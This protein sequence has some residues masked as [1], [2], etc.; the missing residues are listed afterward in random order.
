MRCS[1]LRPMS[2]M[3]ASWDLDPGPPS[4]ISS[5]FS[6]AAIRKSIRFGEA[7]QILNFGLV[8]RASLCTRICRIHRNK[9]YSIC[10]QECRHLCN[11]NGTCNLGRRITC[12][13]TVFALKDAGFLVETIVFVPWYRITCKNNLIWSQGC[14]IPSQNNGICNVG[15]RLPFNKQQYLLSGMQDFL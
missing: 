7:I 1:L 12:K 4:T 8:P 6:N 11:N 10:N 5:N 9:H 15:C 3:S 2:G 14:R 13:K